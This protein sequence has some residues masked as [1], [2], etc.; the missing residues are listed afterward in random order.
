MSKNTQT[1]EAITDKMIAKMEQ[2]NLVWNKPWKG[3][4]LPQNYITKKP[5][6]GWNL[7]STLFSGF[8][9]PFWLTANQIKKLGGSWSGQGTLVIFWNIST[10]EKKNEATNEKEQKKSF[11]L[12]YYYVWNA[13]QITGI[14]FKVPTQ[15]KAEIGTCE[16][17]EQHI[18]NM[19]TPIN[20]KHTLSDQAYY[21]PTFD[22]VN[23]PLKTQ[24][25]GTAEYYSTLIHEVVHSTGHTSRL[26]R[27]AIN[28]GK[29]D[30]KKHSYSFEEL[31]AEIGA[32][33]LN[34]MF[35]IATEESEKNSAA[36]LQGW[37]KTFK[38]DKQMLYK[39]SV[40]AQKAVNY[41]LNDK[42][43]SEEAA[44][45]QNKALKEA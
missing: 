6:Q 13:E 38:H 34:A 40:E 18:Y 23:M 7:F 8:D 21:T 30:G 44:E 19:E 43:P 29:F 45:A 24:F 1:I 16:E 41:I 26:N 11:I 5:Y 27:L 15:T 2:G 10:Y 33:F 25:K 28:D 32:S 12:K 3:N 37:L 31:V 39:A 20:I 42:A 36:Y 14:D 22:Y 17:L 4:S 35:G 9:S